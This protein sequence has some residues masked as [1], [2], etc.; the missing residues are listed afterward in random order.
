MLCCVN[1]TVLFDHVALSRFDYAVFHVVLSW[2]DS[3]HVVC[4]HLALH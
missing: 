2:S 3:D 4:D 1:L